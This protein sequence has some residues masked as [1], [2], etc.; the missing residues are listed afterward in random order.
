MTV[1]KAITRLLEGGNLSVKEMREWMALMVE[2]RITPVQAAGFLIALRAKGESV[3]EIVAAVQ[4]LRDKAQQIDVQGP[5]LIDTCGTGGDGLATFNVSTTA[6]FVVSA[7]G[8]R[9]A[10]HGNRSVSSR[11]GSADVLEAAG[12]NLDL[13]PQQVKRCIEEIGV[14]FLYAPRHH[15]ALKNVA[16]VRRELGVRTLFNLL[17]PLLNPANAPHQLLGVFDGR[18]VD[19]LAQVLQLLGSKHVLVVHAED[20]LDEISLAVPTRVA[21][22]V[23]GRVK[24]YT[25]EPT[26]FGIEPA[27]LETIQARTVEESLERMRSVLEGVPGPAA[28]IVALNAGAAIYAADLSESLSEGIE[29]A[30]DVIAIGAGIKKLNALIDWSQ[31]Q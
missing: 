19:S 3:E 17:G 7:A 10:K 4:V 22:L 9:V 15:G 12:V 25:I 8:G 1:S 16:T 6:A 31:S 28:D 11:C 20:G 26:Q 21:E 13:T 2:G 18:Y 5:H 24:S 30:R 14:G 23:D 29:K 27:P